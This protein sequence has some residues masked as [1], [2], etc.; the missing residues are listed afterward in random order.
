MKALLLAR[1]LAAY[2]QL[3]SQ[4][5][6]LFVLGPIVFGGALLIA[7]RYLMVG[8]PYL[9]ELLSRA[10]GARIFGLLAAFS[11]S[12][13]VA[14]GLFRELYGERSGA[15]LLDLLPVSEGQRLVLAALAAVR[16]TLPALLLWSAGAAALAHWMAVPGPPLLAV[17]GRSF[18]AFFVLVLL[19]LL[20]IQL[21]LR[22]DL[23]RATPLA[24]L[25]AAVVAGL[26]FAPGTVLFL[27]WR[28]PGE[29]LAGVWAESAGQGGATVPAGL[30]LELAL[31]AGGAS[32]LFLRWRRRDAGRAQ[33]LR[34][35]LR[36]LP[37]LPAT[38]EAARALVRRDLLL[39]LRRFSPLV[40]I[41]AA[42][43][44]GLLALLPLLF[45]RGQ[46]APTLLA[47]GFAAAGALAAAAWV[48]LLPY[49]LASQLRT[50]WLESSL[51][52]TAA[53][54]GRAKVFTALLLA[55]PPALVAAGLAL[56]LLPEAAGLTALS[57]LLAALTL[58]L[59]MGLTIWETPLEPAIGLIYGLLVGGAFAA[60]FVVAPKGWP[61]WLMFYF[62]LASQLLGRVRERVAALERP[63]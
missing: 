39:V 16:A 34:A 49:L 23:L 14:A 35:G 27:P 54:L 43:S 9:A 61:F 20:L 29:L 11:F 10:E 51:G 13:A 33:L 56:F 26:F 30:L 5:F 17:A 36:A 6:E 18:L 58:A 42:T 44:I 2:R 15:K 38:G 55:A 31:A 59:T 3:R 60:F 47:R 50:F 45:A 52:T 62:Y 53:Q 41:A 28:L 46:L 1:A 48:A 22:L 32:W 57:I 40:P 19:D 21:A 8:A 25:G 37:L 24:L 4:A 7:D 12:L 63:R